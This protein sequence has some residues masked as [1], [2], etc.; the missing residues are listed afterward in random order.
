MQNIFYE[1]AP[2]YGGH[3]GTAADRTVRGNAERAG[4]PRPIT[5]YHDKELIEDLSAKLARWRECG[6]TG[7]T[8]KTGSYGMADLA[9]AIKVATVLKMD[10][11]T[12]DGSGGGTGMS[13]PEMMDVWGVPSILLH[14]KAYEYASLLASHGQKVVDIALGGGL[15]KTSQIFK[16]LALGSPFV[17][18]VCMSRAFMIPAFLGCN[19]EGALHPERRKEVNGSW[20]ALPKFIA[21]LG[22]T[23]ESI[24]AGYHALELRLGKET[25]KELPY[26]A[27]ATWTMCDRLGAGLQHLMGAARRFTIADITRD[28]IASAN[29]ETERETGIPFITDRQDETAR[30]IL[31]S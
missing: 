16:A 29:R 13:P 7:F 6:A 3:L 23:P 27:I 21:D 18:T 25:M 14:A 24:F 8:L 19:I 17:K 31:L 9:L 30:R 4:P 15:A 5:V 22:V 20:D 10:L 28:D 12:I 2:S 1:L 11:L 26:G